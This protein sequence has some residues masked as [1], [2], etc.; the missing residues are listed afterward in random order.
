MVI[1][2]ISCL[3]SQL[4]VT[5]VIPLDRPSV[6]PSVHHIFLEWAIFQ[7]V[8]ERFTYFSES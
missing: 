1:I 2:I 5:I 3:G 6:N 4:L 7:N 8:L